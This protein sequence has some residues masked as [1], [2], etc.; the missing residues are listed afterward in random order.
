MSDRR[1]RAAQLVKQLR[2]ESSRL[3]ALVESVP[4][5]RWLRVPSPG[6]WSTSKD[7]EH[8]ADAARYHQWIVRS[9]LRQK[10]SATRPSIERTHLK[11]EH[12][13]R[14]VV[15]LIEERTAESIE[16]IKA[17]TPDELELASRPPRDPRRTLGEIIERVMIGH[18]RAH[19]ADISAK[20]NA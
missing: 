2:S 12:S 19:A 18:Y 20:L 16:L 10:V 14:E 7:A 13:Q 8:V 11:A 1:L 5:E 3:V 4:P 17:L 15:A 6:V 9:T